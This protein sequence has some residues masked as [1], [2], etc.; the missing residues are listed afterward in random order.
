MQRA[1]LSYMIFDCVGVG[2]PNPHV[3]RG[4]TIYASQKDRLSYSVLNV[5]CCD[6][7]IAW[8]CRST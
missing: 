5:K 8:Y 7:K 2:R 4:S 1:N 6:S 3:V